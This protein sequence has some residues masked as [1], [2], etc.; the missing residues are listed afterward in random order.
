MRFKAVLSSTTTQSAFRVSSLSV[1]RLLYGCTTTSLVSC[2]LGNTMYVC[3][4]FLPYR[5]FRASN[6]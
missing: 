3:T 1:S 4:R 6:R 5:S 2:W